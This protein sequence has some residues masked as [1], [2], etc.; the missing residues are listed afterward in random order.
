MEG[1]D[2]AGMEVRAGLRKACDR[3]VTG[4]GRGRRSD[5]DAHR[6]AP[7]RDAQPVKARVASPQ[8]RRAALSWR[9]PPRRSGR[10]AARCIAARQYEH[11]EL[12]RL[13]HG[14][15]QL[16]CGCRGGCATWPRHLW[17]PRL[18]GTHEEGTLKL[19]AAATTNG[20]HADRHV[21]P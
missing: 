15:T 8:H 18:L 2:G 1:A 19:G 7:E 6:L 17:H 20:H 14:G 5:R 12:E 11:L 4:W 16:T 10:R 21:T 13:R 3:G 9:E